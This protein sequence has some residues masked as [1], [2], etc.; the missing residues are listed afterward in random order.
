M[1]MN[2]DS[3]RNFIPGANLIS[4]ARRKSAICCDGINFE[5]FRQME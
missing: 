4:K 3:E 1:I 2:A 5:S